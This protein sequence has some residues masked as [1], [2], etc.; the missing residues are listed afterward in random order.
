VAFLMELSRNIALK[1][2]SSDFIF[3]SLDIIETGAKLSC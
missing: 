3:Q 2:L 1:H